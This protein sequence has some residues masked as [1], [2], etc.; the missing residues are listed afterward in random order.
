MIS[1]IQALA[2]CE[3]PSDDPAA[4][5]KFVKLFSGMLGDIARVRIYPG[6]HIRCEFLL[7]G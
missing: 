1:C 2:E 6:K 5:D 4:I 7:P 3:S